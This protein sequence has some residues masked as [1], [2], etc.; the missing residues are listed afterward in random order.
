M[1]TATLKTWVT[2]DQGGP[3]R[4]GW[5]G[6]LL[7]IPLVVEMIYDMFRMAVYVVAGGDGWFAD[8]SLIGGW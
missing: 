2:D 4:A 8:F 1:T 3:L 7:T 6:T 5:A